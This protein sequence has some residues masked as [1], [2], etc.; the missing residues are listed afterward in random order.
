VTNAFDVVGLFV[1]RFDHLR[2]A[3]KRVRV[4]V[5]VGVERQIV[6]RAAE[7]LLLRMETSNCVLAGMF[8]PDA[9]GTNDHAPGTWFFATP[10]ARNSFKRITAEE[11]CAALDR[12]F[13]LPAPG[14]DET[15]A[16]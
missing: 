13:D 9:P 12:M 8:L 11:E 1:G 3:T 4:R 6:K 2:H 7:Q 15:E 14:A 10:E 16:R 5:P